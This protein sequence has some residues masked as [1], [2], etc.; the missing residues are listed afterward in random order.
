M[1]RPKGSPEK[2]FEVFLHVSVAVIWRRALG[3]VRRRVNAVDHH[4]GK[5]VTRS[6]KRATRTKPNTTGRNR[7]EFQAR[8]SLFFKT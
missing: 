1:L 7:F 6:I 4:G 3:R 8:L 5:N 2:A